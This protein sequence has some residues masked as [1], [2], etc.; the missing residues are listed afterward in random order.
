MSHD[1]PEDSLFHIVS[2]G[3]YLSLITQHYHIDSKTLA[4]VNHLTKSDLIDPDQLLRIPQSQTIQ[5]NPIQSN[6]I[7]HSSDF[8]TFRILVHITVEGESFV[9][10]GRRDRVNWRILKIINHL[11]Q[12]QSN[13][14]LL[15]PES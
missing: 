6:L 9:A 5:S 15:I 2:P 14:K 3:E 4:I 1:T 10:I 13:Q 11:T 12:P 7:K 8:S